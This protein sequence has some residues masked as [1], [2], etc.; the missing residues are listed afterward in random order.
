MKN[1]IPRDAV[2]LCKLE[3]RTE[4][5]LNADKDENNTAEDGC[6]TCDFIAEFLSYQCAEIASHEGNNA[7][8]N[9]AD[10]RLDKSV[11]SDGKA[12]GEGV[13]RGGNSLHENHFRG[14]LAACA[15]LALAVASLVDHLCAD[16]A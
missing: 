3:Y 4:K 7:D 14:D 15:F 10:K 6:L 11:R 12:Y 5:D 16:E 13:Y 9:N 2:F 1:C 8:D